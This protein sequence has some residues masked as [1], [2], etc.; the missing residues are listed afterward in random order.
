[1]AEQLFYTNKRISGRGPHE[2]C[3]PFWTHSS[4]LQ[5]KSLTEDCLNGSSGVHSNTAPQRKHHL[6]WPILELIRRL[7]LPVD[8]IV[9]NHF[10]FFGIQ[11]PFEDIFCLLKRSSQ[12]VLLKICDEPGPGLVWTLTSVNMQRQEFLMFY[13]ILVLM[14]TSVTLMM[15][16]NIVYFCLSHLIE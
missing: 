3:I 4:I 2:A 6:I 9:S 13:D 16:L 15:T 5:G 8:N 10:H 14:T 7:M 1:M 11:E 12:N